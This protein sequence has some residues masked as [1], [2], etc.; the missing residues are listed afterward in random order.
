MK[1]RSTGSRG[2]GDGMGYKRQ[3]PDPFND[4]LAEGNFELRVLIPSKS[5]GAII[6]KGGEYINAVSKKVGSWDGN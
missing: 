3:R 1:R 5:A 6:G 2:G 4:A